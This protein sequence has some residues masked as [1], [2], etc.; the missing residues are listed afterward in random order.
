[1]F[2]LHRLDFEDFLIFGHFLDRA[3]FEYFDTADGTYSGYI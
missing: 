2:P 1:V 3:A